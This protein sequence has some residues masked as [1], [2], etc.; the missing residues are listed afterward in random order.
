MEGVNLTPLAL[1]F[2]VAAGGAT[3]SIIAMD[4]YPAVEAPP[5]DGW[6]FTFLFMHQSS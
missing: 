5:Q 2:A 4:P 1:I 6:V 3:Y